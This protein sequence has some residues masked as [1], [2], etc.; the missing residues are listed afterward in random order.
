LW[1]KDNTVGELTLNPPVTLHANNTIKQ[2][3]TKIQNLQFHQFPVVN[4]EHKIVGVVTTTSIIEAI[5]KGKVTLESP[6]SKAVIKAYRK[7]SSSTPISELGRTF[8]RC[9]YAIVDE[10]Y[11]ITHSDYLTFFKDTAE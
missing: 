3:I 9:T 2:A 5:N 1:G 10:K 8:T 6:V 7:I 4:D 11:I